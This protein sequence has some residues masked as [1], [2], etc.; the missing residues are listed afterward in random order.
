MA[1][2][3]FSPYPVDIDESPLPGEDPRAYV[4]RLA[5]EKAR[6]AGQRAPGAGVIL[7]ADTTVADERGLMAKPE[8]PGEAVEML[9]RLRGRPHLVHTGVAVLRPDDGLFKDACTTT[10]YMR[11]Y[12]EEEMAAYVAEGDPMDKAGAYAIQHPGF[13][14]AERI[15]GC[16][17]N[18]MGL[19][20]CLTQAL[21][22]RAGFPPRANLPECPPRDYQNCLICATLARENHA[23]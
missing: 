21:L 4:L 11:E 22:V 16:Y 8:T 1:G 18:V 5:E 3:D 7:A 19:P 20:L 17:S 23:D 10:V 6:A 13:H 15:A 9:T 12:S 14:P 2:W